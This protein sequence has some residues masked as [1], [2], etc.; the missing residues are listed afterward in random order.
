MERYL[1]QFQRKEE[2]NPFNE[3]LL[4]H[5]SYFESF[6]YSVASFGLGYFMGRGLDSLFWNQDFFNLE[7]AYISL[8][9]FPAV[10]GGVLELKYELKRER[11]NSCWNCLDSQKTLEESIN[12]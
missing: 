12:E 5:I 1:I 11:I 3:D 7:L 2:L 9:L 8:G 10:L 6:L 4:G